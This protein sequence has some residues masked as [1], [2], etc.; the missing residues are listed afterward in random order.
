MMP[1]FVISGGMSVT[2][3]LP[4]K[5]ETV[6]SQEFCLCLRS[7][8]L[9][10]HFKTFTNVALLL[11]AFFLPETA[12]TFVGAMALV[13]FVISEMKL[14]TITLTGIEARAGV[15]KKV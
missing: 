2:H 13:I 5:A 7:A 4:E 12:M 15:D 1:K 11:G 6:L 8:F 9:H 3:L 10:S 14:P